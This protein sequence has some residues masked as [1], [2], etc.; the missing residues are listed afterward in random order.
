MRTP[1]CSWPPL[2]GAHVGRA[3][4]VISPHFFLPPRTRTIL[5]TLSLQALTLLSF[6]FPPSSSLTKTCLLNFF[7]KRNSCS[8][9]FP[10]TITTST[11][12]RK[13]KPNKKQTIASTISSPTFPISHTFAYSEGEHKKTLFETLNQ[14]L[15]KP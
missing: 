14:S 1:P 4:V 11:D 7:E 13:Q 2:A 3:A 9:V 8:F 12:L 6:P 15:P 10:P 5:F